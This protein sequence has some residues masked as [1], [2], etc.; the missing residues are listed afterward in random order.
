MTKF[1]ERARVDIALFI[2]SLQEEED[3]SPILVGI[4]AEESLPK[5]H[6]HPGNTQTN[7]APVEIL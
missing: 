5:A 3:S 6:Q 1:N 4:C 7:P 2:T